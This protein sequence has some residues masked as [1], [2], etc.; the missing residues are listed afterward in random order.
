M[1]D[2]RDSAR[3]DA[4][5]R[6][7]DE[8]VEA[9]A[10][11]RAVR[12][13]HRAAAQDRL[14]PGDPRRHLRARPDLQGEGRRGRRG[15]DPHD[16]HLAD[17]PGRRGA[18]A[19]GRVEGAQRRGRVVGGARSRLGPA[20]E[21]RHDVR[22]RASSSSGCSEPRPRACSRSASA[23]SSRSAPCSC[24]SARTRRASPRSSGS[25]SRAI[26]SARVGARA[27]ARRGRG[28]RGAA[29]RPLPAPPAVRGIGAARGRGAARRRARDEL[30]ALA[31][32]RGGS[33][34]P[35]SASTTR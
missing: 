35:G 26:G 4:G 31:R 29:V 32:A 23:R 27:R 30:C 17:V 6:D 28:D 12:R 5:A 19:R 7:F 33:R 21:S 25:T 1:S 3:R 34:A 18:A 14:R 11:M 10:A 20:L 16:A 15:R 9:P 13:S 2:E 8:I 22:G 24:C